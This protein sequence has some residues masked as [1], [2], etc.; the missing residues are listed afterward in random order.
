M[1]CERVNC[2]A[3]GRDTTAASGICVKCYPRHRGWGHSKVT[4][5]GTRAVEPAWDETAIDRDD[6]DGFDSD[7]E[8]HGD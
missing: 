7:R 8:Y 1:T 2:E 4:G 5:G 6:M 3:C